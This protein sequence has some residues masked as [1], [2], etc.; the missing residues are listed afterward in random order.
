[1]QHEL[2]HT[3]T[4]TATPRHSLLITTLKELPVS[5][6][7]VCPFNSARELMKKIKQKTVHGSKPHHEFEEFSAAYTI[8]TR[9]Q[10]QVISGSFAENDLQ[11]SFFNFLL[12]T[13][14]YTITGRRAQTN[15][16]PDYLFL[17][18]SFPAKE[19]YDQ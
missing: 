19:P 14:Y 1:M 7:S 6:K 10:G 2:R 16:V 11:L 8:V 12:R 3:A 15:R 9:L 17:C 18:F 5:A 4:Q 13:H